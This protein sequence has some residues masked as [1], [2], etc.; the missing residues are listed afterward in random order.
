[1]EGKRYDIGNKLDFLKTN[2]EF[3]L[4]RK[5]F[6]GPF[7]KYLQEIVRTHEPK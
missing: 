3:A 7:F 1:I 4:K 2:V 5:E 6:A